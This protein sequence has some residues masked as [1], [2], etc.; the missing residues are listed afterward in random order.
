MKNKLLFTPA[1]FIALISIGCSKDDGPSAKKAFEN[2]N[3]FTTAEIETTIPR[4]EIS[5]SGTTLKVLLS[6][7]D[8]D[9]TPLEEF[10]LG[11]YDVEMIENSNVEMVSQNK[12]ALSVFD[13]S[14]TAP[15]AAATTLDY[16]GS[17]SSRDILDMENALRNFI[18]LKASSDQLSVIKFGSQVEEVQKFTSD[19]TLLNAAIEIHPFIGA[20]TAFYSACH[21][22]LEKANEVSNVLPLVIGFTDGGDNASFISLPEL[23]AKSKNLSIP[24]YTVGFGNA[25]QELL[26]TLAEETGGRFYYAPTGNDIADLYQIINGQLRKLYILE[27]EIDYPSGTELTVQITTNYTAGGGS[28]TDI[29]EKTIIIQ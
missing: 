20:S 4:V 5:Q 6:V 2:L 11:N 27:W 25:R 15:L 29:S 22:G 24:V 3:D 1:L 13:Q 18:N 8:Q 26:Q 17:M 12:I 7:T 10:T 19:T 16:S 14:N 28:F 9:G 23:I 21:L